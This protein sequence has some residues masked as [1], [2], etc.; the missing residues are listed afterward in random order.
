M[1]IE[2]ILVASIAL[3]FFDTIWISGF[4]LGPFTK[5]IE[6]VQKE[7]M[8]VRTSGVVLAYVSLLVL[9]VNFIPKTESYLEA[10]IFGFCVYVVYDATNYATLKNWSLSIAVADSIWGGVLFSLIKY[11]LQ[12]YKL[13]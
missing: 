10:F 3:I 9:A 4:L 7:N 1:N 5:M 12:L 6:N 2:T 13:K 11:F 8:K